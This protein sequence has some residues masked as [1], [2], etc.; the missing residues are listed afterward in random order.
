MENDIFDPKNSK[1]NGYHLSFIPSGNV[2]NDFQDI[3][4]KLAKKYNGVIFEPHVTLLARI[5]ELKEPD[6][7]EKTKQ[8]VEI[9]EPIQ[10]ELKE[11]VTED[12]YFRSLYCKAEPNVKLDRYHQKGL[13]M[14]SMQETNAYTPH[15]SLYYGN[16]NET[17][18]QEMIKSLLLP[19]NMKFLVDKVY[20]YETKGEV[21]AWKR[22]GEYFLRYK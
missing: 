1:T 15:L 21:G 22:I 5:P 3:I 18:K 16:V 6:L 20:L 19:T 10:I 14:F 9:M 8:L 4:Y 13:E 11:I 17:V 7:F 2:F 12:A